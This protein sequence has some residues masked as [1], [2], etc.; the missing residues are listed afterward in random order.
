MRGLLSTTA[1]STQTKKQ[2]DAHASPD[3]GMRLH[4]MS[5]VTAPD[6]STDHTDVR[7]PSD[8]AFLSQFEW[9]GPNNSTI[10]KHLSDC[11]YNAK[12]TISRPSLIS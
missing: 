3:A 5:A 11:S 2:S 6:G 4:K 12:V 7:L 9:R 8:G 10:L 1:S